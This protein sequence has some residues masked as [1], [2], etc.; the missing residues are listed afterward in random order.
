MGSYWHLPRSTPEN[1]KTMAE[2]KPA[3][4]PTKTREMRP[5]TL[6]NHVEQYCKENELGQ[7]DA[8]EMLINS[9]ERDIIEE[10]KSRG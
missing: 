3:T 9:L 5:S 2:K 10:A 1:G 4:K 8:I 7:T 6:L